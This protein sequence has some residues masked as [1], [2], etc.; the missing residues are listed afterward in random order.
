MTRLNTRIRN[1]IVDA[2]I[3]KSGI[4]GEKDELTKRRAAWA[5]VVRI[6]AIGGPEVLAK[7]EAIDRR[8][9][10]LLKDLPDHL[11]GERAAIKTRQSIFLNVAGMRDYVYFSGQFGHRAGGL[12]PIEKITPQEF[13]LKGDNP[14]VHEF[15]VIE[16]IKSELDDKESNL[17]R[18][19]RVTVNKFG[20]I[21]RLTEAWPEAAELLPKDQ[22]P[23]KTNLPAIP[24]KDLNSMI[25]LPTDKAA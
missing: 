17:R 10:R 18:N 16:K 5:E 13:T 2:A 20:T 9:K 1:A 25:G 6:E 22:S 8:L 4:N 15:M 21:K 7:V 12:T 11:V 23:V 24:V 3:E 14:L 19:V